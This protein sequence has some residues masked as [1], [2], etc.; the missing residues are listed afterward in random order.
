MPPRRQVIRRRSSAAAAAKDPSAEPGSSQSG[1]GRAQ[2]TQSAQFPSQERASMGSSMGSSS[3]LSISGSTDTAGGASAAYLRWPSLEAAVAAI[4]A[5]TAWRESSLTELYE[6]VEDAVMKRMGPSLYSGLRAQLERHISQSVAPGLRQSLFAPGAPFFRGAAT[7]PS[8]DPSHHLAGPVSL[9]IES[10]GLTRDSATQA[11]RRITQVF[12]TQ[13]SQVTMVRAIFNYLDRTFVLA[14]GGEL[15]PIWDL[16]LLFFRDYVIGVT[17]SGAP[18]AGLAVPLGGSAGVDLGPNGA[19]PHISADRADDA[20]LFGDPLAVLRL[21]REAVLTLIEEHRKG[22]QV[23]T[24]LLRQ[25]TDM[26]SAL[27][28]YTTQLE[29]RVIAETRVFY[30]RESRETLRDATSAADIA[31][32]C[33]LVARR[34]KEELEERLPAFLGAGTRMDL[35]S[36]LDSVLVSVHGKE[37]VDRG[38][39]GLCDSHRIGDIALLFSLLGL[40]QSNTDVKEGRSSAELRE[41]LRGAFRSYAERVGKV[42][43]NPANPSSSHSSQSSQSSQSSPAAGKST[44]SATP[45]FAEVVQ[46]L[47]DLKALLDQIA[48]EAFRGNERFIIAFREGMENAL[49]AISDEK[50]NGLAEHL[51]KFLDAQLRSSK[52]KTEEEL[53]TLV[54]SVLELFRFIHD[55]NRFQA[56]YQ[57][58]LG[59]RLLLD[60]FASVDLEKSVIGKLKAECGPSFTNKLEGMF[61]D[62]ELSRDLMA[63]YKESESFL[64]SGN[65]ELHVNVLTGGYWPNFPAVEVTLPT[66]LNTQMEAFKDFYTGKHSGRSLQWQHYLG[67]CVLSA[68]FCAKRKELVVSLLQAVVL[69]NFNADGPVDVATLQSQT[70]MDPDDLKRNVASLA[71]GKVRVLKRSGGAKSGKISESDKFVPNADFR[72]KLFRI[73]INGIQIKQ[74]KQEHERVTK[75]VQ[76]DRQHQID[77]ACVRIMKARKQLDHNGL[78]AEVMTQLRGG[79][80]VAAVEIKKRIESLIDR[81]FLE[82]GDDNRSYRYLA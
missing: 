70:G 66:L 41:Y 34:I 60:K 42:L 78:V 59:K 74:T 37:L 12:E 8:L 75:A 10:F 1:G 40:P 51:A 36:T 30:A 33:A 31:N 2:L 67:N 28:I 23:D 46:K 45:L 14:S 29:P 22:E 52:G 53:D 62:M 72:H 82:R 26:F 71:T 43:A 56:F 38:F 44:A 11:L 27:N 77:A 9:E 4:L 39:D 57:S 61:K 54:D 81:Q 18:F 24:D 13:C 50:P 25:A 35:K 3:S 21:A 48:S 76:Q 6:S 79:F 15:R 73:R 20:N 32:Y 17:E 16:G 7:R 65:L 58:L 5:G 69:L 49:N 19:Y 64:K 63:E 80:S 47:L 55:K 68:N